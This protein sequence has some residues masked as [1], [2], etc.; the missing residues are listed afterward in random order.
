MEISMR[1]KNLYLRGTKSLT[2]IQIGCICMGW[3]L[4]IMISQKLPLPKY[5]GQKKTGHM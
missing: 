1:D 5:Y 3:D 4:N 2:N